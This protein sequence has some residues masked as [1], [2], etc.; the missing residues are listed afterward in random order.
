MNWTN[1]NKP[2]VWLWLRLPFV[3]TVSVSDFVRLVGLTKFCELTQFNIFFLSSKRSVIITRYSLYNLFLLLLLFLPPGVYAWMWAHCFG[4]GI[5]LNQQN[6]RIEWWICFSIFCFPSS[7]ALFLLCLF[8]RISSVFFS[9]SLSLSLVYAFFIFIGKLGFLFTN[10]LLMVRYVC[11][12]SK[13]KSTEYIIFFF[14]ANTVNWQRVNHSNRQTVP[15]YYF[16]VCKAP[17]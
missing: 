7:S 16:C 13:C 8:L 17:K 2:N 15:T 10:F 4:V 5:S 6:D 14:F 1:N 12:L 9:F 3:C 11:C